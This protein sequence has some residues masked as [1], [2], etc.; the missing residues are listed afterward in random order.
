MSNT[1]DAALQQRLAQ[2][3][4]SAFRE[5]FDLYF[6]GLVLFA[7]KYSVDK[8]AAEDLVQDVLPLNVH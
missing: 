5:V 6:K 7:T 1:Q 3:D 8:E 4:E 2:G